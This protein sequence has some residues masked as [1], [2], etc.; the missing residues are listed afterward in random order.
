MPAAEQ[1]LARSPI[2]GLLAPDERASLVRMG[3]ERRAAAGE[4]LFL[5]GEPC[6]RVQVLLRGVVRL[7]RL[8]PDGHVLALRVCG[9]GDVLGQMSA[10]D[11]APHSVNATA[12]QDC[13]LLVFPAGAFCEMLEQRP[14]LALRL[15]AVLAGIV[16]GLSDEL[17]AMKFA[18]V[19]DRVLAWLRQRGA[20]RRELRVTHQQIAE[21]VG[22]TRENVSRVLG[23]LRDRGA[24]RLG[25]G[26]IEL[27][28]HAA[29]ER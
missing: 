24:L 15:V 6:E 29:L 28:D 3:R 20:G 10:V 4:D 26:R 19:A 22:A 9:P 27:L 11:G 12:E 1:I 16:R 25:R 13:R 7:W 23:L 17:E 8:T 5:A 14:A 18:S 2:F 21:Q